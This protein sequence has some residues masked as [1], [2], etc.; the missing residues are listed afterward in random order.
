[1]AEWLVECAT[2]EWRVGGTNPC[3]MLHEIVGQYGMGQISKVTHEDL[4]KLAA[5]GMIQ[6]SRV[7]VT[8]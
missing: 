2:S 8:P 3:G 4:S 5:L 6:V 7:P 1:M